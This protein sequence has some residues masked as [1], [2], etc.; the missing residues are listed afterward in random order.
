MLNEKQLEIVLD[1][2]GYLMLISSP[3]FFQGGCQV[4][5]RRNAVSNPSSH[6]HSFLCGVYGVADEMTVLLTS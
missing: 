4:G 2:H 5:F 1:G 3:A 6:F